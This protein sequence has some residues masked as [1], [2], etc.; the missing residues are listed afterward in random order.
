VFP[1]FSGYSHLQLLAVLG[2]LVLV[3]GVATPAVFN[4]CDYLAR[5]R[6]LIDRT[7]NY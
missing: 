6:G 4:A 5:E 1:R 3:L 2:G 7:T